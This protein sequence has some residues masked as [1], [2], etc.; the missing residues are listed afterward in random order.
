MLEH[1]RLEDLVLI[2]IDRPQR[3]IGLDAQEL[4]EV[5]DLAPG[6]LQSKRSRARSP[7]DHVQPGQQ[8]LSTTWSG[9][10]S[11]GMGTDWSAETAGTS[12]SRGKGLRLEQGR[13]AVARTSA[14]HLTMSGGAA[15]SSCRVIVHPVLCPVRR[16]QGQEPRQNHR[17]ETPSSLSDSSQTW[18]PGSRSLTTTTCL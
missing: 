16:D 2:E 15:S 11:T 7:H 1:P 17:R 14:G 9:C 6:L 8:C 3:G 13:C 18:V 4:V 12:S 5:E 10:R